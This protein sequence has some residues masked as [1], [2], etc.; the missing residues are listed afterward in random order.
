MHS[1]LL[2]LQNTKEQKTIPIKGH[3]SSLIPLSAKKKFSTVFSVTLH[4]P[5]KISKEKLSVPIACR[6]F[7]NYFQYIPIMSHNLPLEKS[8]T[9]L[10]LNPI[11]IT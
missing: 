10:C 8:L 6:I 5:Y 9:T 3:S 4:L 1:S 2:P 7:L 11:R